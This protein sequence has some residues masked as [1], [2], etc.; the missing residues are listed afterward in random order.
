MRWM[1]SGIAMFDRAAARRRAGPGTSGNARPRAAR[2]RRGSRGSLPESCARARADPARASGVRACGIIRI[3]FFFSRPSVPA[4]PAPGPSRSRQ[5]SLKRSPASRSVALDNAAGGT[6]G[7]R[8]RPGGRRS[9]GRRHRRISR[10]SPIFTRQPPHI[11][12]PSTI[13]GFRLTIVR[14]RCGR[15]AS[16]QPFIIMGGP[17]AT[18]SSMSGCSRP[19]GGCPR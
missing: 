11:P 19:P 5:L 6:S 18:H 7:R 8:S 9:P 10:R 16:A 1:K 4:S 17:M 15:V 14:I 2:P 3:V 12:V 13:T